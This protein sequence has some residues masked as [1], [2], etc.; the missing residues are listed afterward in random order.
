VLTDLGKPELRNPPI[1]LKQ[2]QTAELVLRND[3]LL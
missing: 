3:D 2:G 1:I